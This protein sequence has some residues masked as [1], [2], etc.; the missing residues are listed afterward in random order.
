M[1]SLSFFQL[2]LCKELQLPPSDFQWSSN[3]AAI[4]C[5][6]SSGEAPSLQVIK[7][8]ILVFK[9]TLRIILNTSFFIQRVYSKYLKTY[10]GYSEGQD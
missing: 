6:N 9:S 4:S 7:F 3:L 10:G 1:T 2:S 5:L 8:S